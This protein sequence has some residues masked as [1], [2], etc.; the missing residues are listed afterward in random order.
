[1]LSSVLYVATEDAVRA[2]LQQLECVIEEDGS[3]TGFL[4]RLPIIKDD[5][6]YVYCYLPRAY[7]GIGYTQ[8]QLDDI[9]QQLSYFGI[10]LLPLDYSLL[11][12]N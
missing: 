4:V 10:D 11:I 2:R 7:G 3:S 6:K 8:A 5:G 1:M 12:Q 9:E